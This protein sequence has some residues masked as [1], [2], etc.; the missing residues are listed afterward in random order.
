MAKDLPIT[1]DGL[2]RKEFIKK[3]GFDPMAPMPKGDRYDS[4]MRKL[5]QNW[6]KQQLA[7]SPKKRK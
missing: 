6:R 7:M 4:R 5:V 1:A 2:T 3:W